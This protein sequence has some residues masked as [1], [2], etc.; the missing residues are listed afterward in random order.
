MMQDD[1]N[2]R[3]YCII[4]ISLYK[5]GRLDD[6]LKLLRIVQEHNLNLTEP[7]YVLL[8]TGICEDGRVTMAVEL[9]RESLERSILLKPPV[10]N[11]I[12]RSLCFQGRKA[13]AHELLS[14]MVYIGYDLNILLDDNMTTVRSYL[15]TI[16]ELLTLGLLKCSNLH[17]SYCNIYFPKQLK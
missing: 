1:T 15:T 13:K 7:A 9:F 14:E 10:C 17:S 12:L 4:I 11:K 16:V 6:A 2:S 8:I 5:V 3:A